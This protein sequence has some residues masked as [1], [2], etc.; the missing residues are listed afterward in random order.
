MPGLTM[1]GEAAINPLYLAI[2]I[3]A[4]DKVLYHGHGVAAVAATG[5]HIA[6]EAL[7]LIEVE[8]EVLPPVLDV[9]EAM[10]PGAPIV[11]SA[12]RQKDQPDQRETNIAGEFQF[13]RGD[14]DAGFK[15]ADYIVER[16]F[17][18]EM[19]H[20]GYIEPPNALGI[21]QSDGRATIYTSTQGPFDVRRCQ[22]TL[23]G[24]PEGNVKVIPAEIGGGFGAKLSVHV[25]PVALLLAKH[26]GRP[27]K[28]VM[29]RTEVLR[30]TGP[31]SGSVLRIKMGATKDGK[32]TAAQVWNAYEAGGFPG[33]PVW[34][35]CF[36]GLSPYNIA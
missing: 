32:I 10:K 30:A 3:M 19:V 26:T 31:T 9:H 23:L 17:R 18:T 11:N 27:V 1:G 35:G 13:K 33:S 29:T 12:I 4:T 6:E 21:Y 15:A 24:L 25:E 5:P 14:I 2:N 7:D 16:E 22:A 34:L 20:Q 28:M 8:Y 36:T